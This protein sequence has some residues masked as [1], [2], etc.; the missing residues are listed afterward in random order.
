MVVRLDK[1]Y[2]AI[3]HPT[4]DRY[5][6]NLGYDVSRVSDFLPRCRQLSLRFGLTIRQNERDREVEEKERNASLNDRTEWVHNGWCFQSA[7][8]LYARDRFRE[9]NRANAECHWS[10]TRDSSRTWNDR[11]ARISLR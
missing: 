6:R 8:S 5:N 3:T 2:D 1:F 11:A 4:T 7:C 10:N 9:R